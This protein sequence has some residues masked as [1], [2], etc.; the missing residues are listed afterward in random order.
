M[1][2]NKEFCAEIEKSVLSGALSTLEKAVKKAA[3]PSND[4]PPDVVVKILTHSK[5]S[6]KPQPQDSTSIPEITPEP[7]ETTNQILIT[8]Q[9]VQNAS[10]PPYFP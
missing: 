10:P 3:N 7:P 4:R 1:L 9:P 5:A 8:A 6:P 2:I